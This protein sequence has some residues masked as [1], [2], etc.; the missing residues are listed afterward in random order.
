MN[1][2]RKVAKTPRSRRLKDNSFLCVLYAFATLREKKRAI[3]LL[4]AL[5]AAPVAAQI[6][7][8]N[9]EVLEARLEA[10]RGEI[11]TIQQRIE[12]DRAQH[13]E[14]TGALADAEREIGRLGRA[15]RE[16]ESLIEDT[17]TGLDALRSEE[18][19]LEQSLDAEEDELGEQLRAAY[20]AGNQSRLRVIL[21]QDEPE[22]ITRALAYH[23]YLTRARVE[24][25]ERVYSQ[26]EDLLDVRMLIE[27]R[28]EELDHLRSEQ[29]ETLAMQQQART[30]RAQAM[31]SIEARIIDSQ[32]RLEEL[33]RN[34]EELERLI[35]QL[36]DAL[37]DIPPEVEIRPFAELRGH[38]PVPVDGRVRAHFGQRRSEQF[39]WKGWLIAGDAGSEVRAVAHGRVAF[40]DWLRG[41]GMVLILDHGD[42]YMTLYAHNESLLSD[43]GDWVRPSQIIA[44]MGDSGGER[45]PG[46]YFELRSQGRAVDPAPWMA[47]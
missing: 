46:L 25:M 33:E 9:P 27:S 45:E 41:Y 23:S 7:D 39:E 12:D 2:S 13:D 21:N 15:L 6:D 26:L 31:E 30:Q 8:E 20:R 47:R 36:T 1:A 3:L 17:N 34:A 43:V 37:A 38:L 16:T 35:E 18:K 11:A 32:A 4:L 29:T 44:T 10:L 19:A 42:G 28:L 24:I 40:S 5:C 14:I 22:R